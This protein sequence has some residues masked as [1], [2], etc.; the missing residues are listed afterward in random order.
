[1]L[2]LVLSLA[3]VATFLFSGLILIRMRHWWSIIGMTVAKTLAASSVI[4][5]AIW[6]VMLALIGVWRRS[7]GIFAFASVGTAI[8]TWYGLLVTRPHNAFEETFGSDWEARIPPQ[9]HERM[10]PSRRH[11]LPPR[12]HRGAFHRD[13]VVGKKLDTE[14]PLLADLWEPPTDVPKTGLVLLYLHGGAWHYGDKDLG[15][16]YFFRHLTGQGHV[17]LDLSYTMANKA[18]LSDMIGDVKE[19]VAWLKKNAARYGFDPAR[20]VVAGGSAGAHLA[21]LTAYTPNDHR[22]QPSYTKMD[23]S[24]RAVVAFY[25]PVDL[26]NIQLRSEMKYGEIFKPGSLLT[27]VLDRVGAYPLGLI[28]KML[29]GTPDEVPELYALGSPVNHVSAENPPTLVIQ[30]THDVFDWL[31][32]T[33]FFIQKLR[34]AG[35]TTVYVE[36]PFTDHAFDLSLPRISPAAQTAFYDVDRFLALMV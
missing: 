1:V 16:R 14:L 20:I 25:P 29:G 8:A 26:R 2:H 24:I 3:A 6:G 11:F 23:T 27:R 17:V 15:T 32:D 7:F 30:G 9:L 5:L 36:L 18:L 12:A 28:P 19:S 34:A 31:S 4:P 35:V 22:F 10:M 21:L 33:R 13:I